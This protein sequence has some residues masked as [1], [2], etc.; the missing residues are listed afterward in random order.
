MFLSVFT[1]YVYDLGALGEGIPPLLLIIS[2]ISVYLIIIS[3]PGLI[4]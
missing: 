1:P 4:S 3:P 2:F